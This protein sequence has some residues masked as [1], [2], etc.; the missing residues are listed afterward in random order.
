MD[1]NQ[2][3]RPHATPLSCNQVVNPDLCVR[4]D[5]FALGLVTNRNILRVCGANHVTNIAIHLAKA[6]K[7]GLSAT[8]QASEVLF[9]THV[10]TIVADFPS[11]V[12][13][14]GSVTVFPKLS[15]KEF[16][17]LDSR[18]DIAI[19]RHMDSTHHLIDT[20][21]SQINNNGAFPFSKTAFQLVNVAM[22]EHRECMTRCAALLEAQGADQETINEIHQ[23]TVWVENSVKQILQTVLQHCDQ[24]DSG[25]REFML[26]LRNIF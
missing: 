5:H 23:S 24:I 20:I 16:Q 12:K 15:T 18:D 17:G 21:V 2:S 22:Q 10:T 25:N 13:S 8:E 19:I 9:V 7:D 26:S 14:K 6:Y 4:V 11:Q 1:F 3:I